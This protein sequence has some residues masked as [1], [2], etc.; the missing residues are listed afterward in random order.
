MSSCTAI[1]EENCIGE[2]SFRG[3]EDN[4]A[5]QN[6]EPASLKEAVR[7]IITPRLSGDHSAAPSSNRCMQGSQNDLEE[8]ASEPFSPRPT[9]EGLPPSGFTSQ[10][11]R[12]L[13][14]N[15][16]NENHVQIESHRVSSPMNEAILHVCACVCVQAQ[17]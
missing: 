4:T 12:H 2:K 15:D 5:T 7:E 1:I 11:Y 13:L 6:S 16:S 3:D 10:P 8:C 14:Y 17:A 9:T